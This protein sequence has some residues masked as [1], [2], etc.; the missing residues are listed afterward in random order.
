M[1]RRKRQFN[2]FNL[3]FLDIMSCGF[4][5][6]ILFFVIINHAQD[7]R[8]DDLTADLS[9][10]VN[11]VET[12]L[13]LEQLNLAKLQNALTEVEEEIVTAQG[14]SDRLLSEVDDTEK[15]L[16][17]QDAETAAKREH[18]N[19]LITDL[20]ALEKERDRLQQLETE[21]GESVRSYTGEGDRQY[22]T[23]LRVGGRRIAIFVD[24]SAS[25]L[26]ET[27]VNVIRRR[28]LPDEQKL[29][30]DK[31]QRVVRTVDWITTQVPEN[32]QFQVYT[33]NTKATPALEGT[34]GQWLDVEKG[35]R[36]DEAVDRIRSIIPTGGTRLH[37]VTETINRM[38]PLPD[39]V[40]LLVDGLPT[41]GLN[42]ATKRGTVT[43]RERER[44][45]YD[46]TAD[47]PIG[48]PVNTILFPMEGDP[49]AA[50]GFWRLAILSG[51][52]FITPAKDWP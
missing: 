47:L 3:S 36:L 10:E 38:N 12:E 27:I 6:V 28:N 20:K 51:G 21:G 9:G 17:E 49:K 34:D 11:L 15:E 26:D 29:R 39:N 45:F 35:R 2:A 14:A 1:P 13:K 32:A 33:F 48:V 24:A 52:S 46:A 41:Q 18:M 4:G 42:P 44:F 30:A 22:L 37:S 50:S 40:F 25:M 5:A 31:W 8:N 23:G 43:S 19:Q 7:E 16:S